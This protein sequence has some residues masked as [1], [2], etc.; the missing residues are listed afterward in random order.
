MAVRV[1]RP[2]IGCEKWRPLSEI[3][4]A[5]AEVA[6]GRPVLSVGHAR[7]KPRLG[8]TAFGLVLLGACSSQDAPLATPVVDGGPS[9]TTQNCDDAPVPPGDDGGAQPEVPPPPDYTLVSDPDG[10]YA[11]DLGVSGGYLYWVGG[12]NRIVRAPT[13]GGAAT[14]LFVHPRKSSG[15]VEIGGMVVDGAAVY[16]T[17]PRDMGQPGPSKHAPDR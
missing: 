8:C 13:A 6:C 9:C 5:T 15:V 7:M 2:P 4:P 11:S 3:S 10:A 12:T 16:F 1:G 14:T 17:D